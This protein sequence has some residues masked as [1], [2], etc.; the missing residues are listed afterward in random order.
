MKDLFEHVGK[1]LDTDTF[2]QAIKKIQD[3]LKSRTKS[4]VQRNLLLS[5]FPQGKKSFERW[6]KEVSNTAKLINYDNYDWKCAAADAILLQTANSKLRER[7]IQE[8]ID[9]DK[10]ITLGIAKEQ[11]S[12]GA[13]QLEVASGQSSATST[14]M[15]EVRRL[16]DENKKLRQQTKDIQISTDPCDRCGY[17]NC[18]RGKKCTAV[19]Q[20]CTTCKKYDHFES[21]CRSK[22]S[23]KPKKH[24]KTITNSEQTL[25]CRG[26]LQLR[27]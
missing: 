5:N 8:D 3:G 12:K 26:I 4:A 9:Y 11:S 10:F 1:V 23:G 27:F 18:K 16:R 2:D 20:K 15:E 14:E 19:G 21:V 22:T 13:A 24:K 25:Q 7:A 6:S 17:E